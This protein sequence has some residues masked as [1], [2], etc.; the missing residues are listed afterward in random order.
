MAEGRKR[1]KKGEEAKKKQDRKKDES[2]LIPWF[3]KKTE[4]MAS[5]INQP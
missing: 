2:R 4:Q 3:G 5:T 1:G